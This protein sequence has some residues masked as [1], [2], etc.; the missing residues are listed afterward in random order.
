MGRAA[1]TA[2]WRTFSAI[3]TQRPARGTTP[4][5]SYPP[6]GY[7]LFDV[8]GNVWEWVHDWYDPDYYS[9]SPV[10][11]PEGPPQGHCASSA[12]AAGWWPTSG[13]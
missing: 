5:G 13:C 10:E 8:A 6:N 2:I 9:T 3:P 12:A 1:R 11:N 7:G 4:C